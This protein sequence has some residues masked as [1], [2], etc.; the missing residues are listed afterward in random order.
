MEAAFGGKEL[1]T[2]GG[3]ALE[4]LARHHRKLTMWWTPPPPPPLAPL[5]RVMRRA[6]EAGRCGCS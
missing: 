2:E 6:S 4:G 3:E 1:S 5:S